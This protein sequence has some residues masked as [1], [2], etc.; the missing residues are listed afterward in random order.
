VGPGADGVAD[1]SVALTGG[2]GVFIGEA[3]PAVLPD[4]WVQEERVAAGTATSFE[5]GTAPYRTRVLIRRPADP[6]AFNGTVVVEWLNVSGGVD[7]SPDYSFMANEIHRGGYAWVGVSAQY[8]GVEGGAV[9][10]S[11]IDGDSP[12]GKGLKHIDPERYGGLDHPGDAFAYD[13]YTQVARA[14]RAGLGE[15]HPERVLAVGESQS[16]AMLVTYAN[17]VQR[18]VRA[19]DGMLIHSRGAGAGPPGDAGEGINAAASFM[20]GAV[21]VRDDV[22]VPVLV[23]QMET[24][25]VMMGSSAV[26]QDDTE[27]FRLWEVAGAAHADRFL[28]GPMA[29]LVD[30]GGPVNDGPQRFVVPAALRALD[31][32]VRDAVAPP[33]S[34]RLAVDGFN[35]ERDGDGIILSGIR[36]P[37]VDV[38]VEVLSGV[39]RPSTSLICMLLGATD[40][41]PPE[42]IAELYPSRAAY[43]DAYAE[44]ADAVIAAGF[45][46]PEDRDALLAAAQPDLV[47][48][49]SDS[50]RMRT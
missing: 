2:N 13:I 9:L 42:R 7:A 16:A 49:Q 35:A 43:L 4:G 31:R 26:R 19:F 12:A 34:P 18:D 28:L 23:V 38:P 10:V 32:W 17:E 48:V 15:L 39:P 40:P 6:S 50:R 5:A 3:T 46:L 41:L 20:T 21:A 30:C 44:S 47:T 22:G 8:F 29:A 25:V 11:V 45:V 1:L 14:L 24:D 27:S 36:T 33:C 37:L